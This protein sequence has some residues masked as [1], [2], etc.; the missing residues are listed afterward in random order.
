MYCH[1]LKR[2]IDLG[3]CHEEACPHRGYCRIYRV[4]GD[5][6]TSDVILVASA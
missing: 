2:K 4:G 1:D 3:V 6:I 5:H